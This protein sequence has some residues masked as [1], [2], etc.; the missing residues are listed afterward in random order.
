MKTWTIATLLALTVLGVACIFDVQESMMSF[1]DD[2]LG[3]TGFPRI[4]GGMLALAAGG[5][6]VHT[7]FKKGGETRSMSGKVDYRSGIALVLSAGYILGV[8]KLGFVTSTLVYLIGL[9]LLF[10]KF[11]TKN[12][13]GIAI[14]S[15]GVTLAAY[16]FFKFFKVY[17]P[18][19]IWY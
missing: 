7:A 16:G 2:I 12:L 8:S 11:K 3:V 19:T 6:A 14:Y 17:L 1:G 13:P 18:D 5:L 4:V 9:S 10:D 15:I